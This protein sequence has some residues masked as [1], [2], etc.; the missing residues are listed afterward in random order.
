LLGAQ[1]VYISVKAKIPRTAPVPAE[2]GA[3]LWE[4]KW[5]LG[6]PVLIIGGL[7]S[8][9]TELD[10][11]AALAALYVLVIEVFVYKDI[12]LRD[13]PRIA[14]NSMALAGAVV[15]IM[16]MAVS[17]TNFIVTERIPDQLFAF[18]T[19]IGIE[20]AW[21][22]LIALNIFLYVQGMLMDGF[23]SIL[24]AVPLLIPF[25]ARFG[26]SPFH[27][28]MM[29]LL[30][31]E[32]AYL[33]PPLGQNLFVTSFRFNRPMAALYRIA[34]PFLGILICG[35]VL[36]MTIPKLSTWLI[37]DD[38]VEARAEAAKYDAPPREAWMLECVQEDRNNP[39]PC[40][41]E[42]KAKYGE[43]AKVEDAPVDFDAPAPSAEPEEEQG[44]GDDELEALFEMEGAGG[45][46]AKEPETGGSKGDLPAEDPNDALLEE[47]LAE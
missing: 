5:E 20:H 30:N 26:L 4:L 1:A 9:L 18:V 35:L 21:Q 45:G 39:L 16:A 34:L 12:E 29:F 15:L 37:E 25:A 33:S 7:F 47:M 2:M 42:D 40:S 28:A 14:R 24:V 31:L 10:E 38:I 36:I 3:S 22:F 43:G 8:G 46:Q 41:A 13:F 11:S 44:F 6:I 17:L 19:G 23:S 32:I 27:L